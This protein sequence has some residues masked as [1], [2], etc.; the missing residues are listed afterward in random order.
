MKQRSEIKKL[1]LK[2]W[3][4]FRGRGT[5][6]SLVYPGEMRKAVLGWLS[7]RNTD[8][9]GEPLMAE[10]DMSTFLDRVTV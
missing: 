3:S 2:V 8:P 10:R 6:K 5:W 7:K 9:W 4:E 1:K